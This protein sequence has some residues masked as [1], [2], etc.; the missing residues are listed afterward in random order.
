MQIIILPS[1]WRWAE[2]SLCASPTG[3]RPVS[4]VVVAESICSGRDP[5]SYELL[6]GSLGEPALQSSHLSLQFLIRRPCPGWHS[7]GLFQQCLTSR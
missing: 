2:T 6:P 7:A 1:G 3:R 5:L 4:A